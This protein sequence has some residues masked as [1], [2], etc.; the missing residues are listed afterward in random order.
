MLLSS[1]ATALHSSINAVDFAGQCDLLSDR[2]R[3]QSREMEPS[4]YS[5]HEVKPIIVSES[6]SEINI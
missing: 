4:L 2:E 5:S 1:P 6:A 3:I